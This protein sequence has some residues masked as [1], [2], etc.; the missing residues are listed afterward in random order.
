MLMGLSVVPIHVNMSPALMNNFDDRGYIL[1]GR[2]NSLSTCFLQLFFGGGGDHLYLVL[3]H[4][5]MY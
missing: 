1:S 2:L 4:N 3:V 5:W